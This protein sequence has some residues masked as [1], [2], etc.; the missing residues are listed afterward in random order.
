MERLFILLQ[1]ITPQHL[2]SRVAGHVAEI[3]WPW[4]KN[5]LISIF[6]RVYRVD[7]TESARRRPADFRN[8]NDFFTRELTDDARTP[9]GSV[10]SPADGT[11]SALGCIDG[12]KVFQAKGLNYSLES[13]LAS[14][15]VGHYTDGSFITIYLAPDNY[16][17][18][19]HPVNGELVSARYIPGTLFSV[20]SNTTNRIPDLF[21]RNER[22]VCD[23]RSGNSQH[24]VVMVGAMIVAGIQPFWRSSAYAP[25]EYCTEIFQPPKD[26]VQA[27]E[28]GRFQLGSTVILLFTGRVDWKVAAG[29][30]VRFGDAL[31]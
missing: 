3:R 4:F 13:L 14:T 25:G 12:R 9:C 5:M 6:I 30:R 2:L 8:F 28:L 7:M 1:R 23:F 21:A 18:V 20:N 29:D 24:C 26:C 10:T 15:D 19:H 27:Q 17:R 31:A 16:H 11:V 22:L